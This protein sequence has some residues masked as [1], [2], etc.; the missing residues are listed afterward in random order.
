MSRRDK[1]RAH[2][3]TGPR[4]I[5]FASTLRSPRGASM[6]EPPAHLSNFAMRTPRTYLWQSTHCV[7]ALT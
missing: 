7:V 1:N 2:R 4:P 5:Q 6:T 3:L